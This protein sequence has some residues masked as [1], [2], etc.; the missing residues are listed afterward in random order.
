MSLQ[1]LL[2]AAPVI[3]LHVAAACVALGVGPLA[4]YRK[5]RDFWHKVAGY[6]WVLAMGITALSSFWIHSFPLI[7]PFSPIHLLAIFALWSL[8]EGLRHVFAGRIRQ[9]QN[10]MLG[11]Y[12]NGLILAGL[13]NFLPGRVINRM[14]FGQASD[15]GYIILG[16]GLAGIAVSASRRRRA[17]AA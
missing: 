12:W 17:V 5:R 2:E 11:L 7:G 13:F 4:I 10:A 14:V 3:Q 8:Y 6:G 1:P 16:L 15:L 9:H